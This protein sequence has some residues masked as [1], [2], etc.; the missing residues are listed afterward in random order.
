MMTPDRMLDV[1]T[2]HPFPGASDVR[3]VVLGCHMVIAGQRLVYSDDEW[4]TDDRTI[5]VAFPEFGN[6]P[7]EDRAHAEIRRVLAVLADP[8]PTWA[9]IKADC[10]GPD[11]PADDPLYDRAST[12][13]AL[14]KFNTECARVHDE[15]ERLQTRLTDEIDRRKDT[16]Q[17]LARMTAERDQARQA[18]LDLSAN[19]PLCPTVNAI[20]ERLGVC[21]AEPG[22]MLSE[23]DRLKGLADAH[24]VVSQRLVG[25]QKDVAEVSAERD[26]ATARAA[27]VEDRLR[28]DDELREQIA[29]A[30]GLDG[31]ASLALILDTMTRD[32]PDDP[33]AVKD[34]RALVNYHQAP[35]AFNARPLT[36]AERASFVIRRLWQG[37]TN[38]ANEAAVLRRELSD[39]ADAL[40][41]LPDTA[42]REP[43]GDRKEHLGLSTAERIRLS[44]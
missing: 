26:E 9:E 18:Y 37:R 23:V 28:R 30:V 2:Q 5:P 44:R 35:I 4:L 6:L 31:A 33:R 42:E 15:N 24:A 29:V 38:A 3:S 41:D 40:G 16:E 8:S 27:K 43:I 22:P 19:N 32:R 20:A 11:L 36:L 1:L 14:A 10:V 17:A 12:E 25:S 34:L 13:Q 39:I 7:D 21:P